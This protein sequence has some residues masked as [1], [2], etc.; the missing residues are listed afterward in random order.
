MTQTPSIKKKLEALGAK[1]S[2][3][4]K[5]ACPNCGSSLDCVYSIKYYAFK[6]QCESCDFCETNQSYD[7][8]LASV[9]IFTLADDEENTEHTL[10]D[11]L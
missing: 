7:G 2:K 4:S 10:L 8:A 11:S 3:L 1:P 5:L 9:S 6:V